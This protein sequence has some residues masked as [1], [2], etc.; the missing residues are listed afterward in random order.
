[1]PRAVLPIGT[2]AHG[3]LLDWHE[4]RRAQLLHSATGVMTVE[5]GDGTWTVSAD[6]AV[7]HYVRG[8]AHA[9]PAHQGAG[10]PGRPTVTFGTI[11]LCGLGEEHRG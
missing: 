11:G 4:R 2:Y 3:Q 1:V 10:E 6:R 5:T 7:L 8:S 9:Q